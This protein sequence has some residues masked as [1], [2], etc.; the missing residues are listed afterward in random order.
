MPITGVNTGGAVFVQ[1]FEHCD[2][3]GGS[4]EGGA[5][6]GKVGD[7]GGG[8]GGGEGKGGDGGGGTG[9]GEGG[10]EVMQLPEP[11]LRSSELGP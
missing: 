6:E 9:G 1:E 8:T 3:G 2:D 7:G 5:G 4:G 10:G 11:Q